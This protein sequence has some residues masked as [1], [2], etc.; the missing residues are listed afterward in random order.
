MDGWTSNKYKSQ[1][2]KKTDFL[3]YDIIFFWRRG[4]WIDVDLLCQEESTRHSSK[5]FQVQHLKDVLK[6]THNN[7]KEMQKICKEM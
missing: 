6:E 5:S 2:L 4:C 7:H 3:D 1:K